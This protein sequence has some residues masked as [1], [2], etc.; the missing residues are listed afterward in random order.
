MEQQPQI[1]LSI[2]HMRVLVSM[3]LDPSDASMCWIKEPIT[4]HY[5]LSRHDEFC[6][7]LSCLSPVPTYT[8]EDILMKIKGT[9]VYNNLIVRNTSRNTPW[10]YTILKN[11][12]SC[13]GKGICVY[14]RTPLE[15]A[16]NALLSMHKKAPQCIGILK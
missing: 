16:Y 10:T 11:D 4:E 13:I 8:L 9:L 15:A 5:A 6:Y 7:E 3:G 2:E 14:G 12:Y 1:A